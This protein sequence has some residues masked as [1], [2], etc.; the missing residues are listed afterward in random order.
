MYEDKYHMIKNQLNCIVCTQCI[1]INILL[2]KLVKYLY[3]IVIT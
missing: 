3:F 1:N 2:V